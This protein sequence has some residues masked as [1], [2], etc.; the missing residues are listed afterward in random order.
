MLASLCDASFAFWGIFWGEGNR[1]IG[2]VSP[3][4]ILLYITIWLYILI[5]TILL[6]IL[7]F[8]TIFFPKFN[9]L[10]SYSSLYLKS[11]LTIFPYFGLK[12]KIGTQNWIPTSILVCIIS[13][14]I[15]IYI[16]IYK[17]I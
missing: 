17:Y 5:N 6:Y 14:Y 7:F 13:L 16:Y 2:A 11:N 9:F 1:G 8:K 12:P 3:H 4:L 10:A 15:Y